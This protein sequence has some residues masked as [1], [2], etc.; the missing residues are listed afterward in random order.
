MKNTLALMGCLL[1]LVAASPAADKNVCL[2]CHSQMDAP[3]K[4][5]QAEFASNIHAEKGLTCTSCHGGDA[6]SDENPMSRAAGFR[7]HIE[8]RQVPELCGSCHGD[9]AKMR[10]YNPSLRTDQ[11][12]QYK[13]SV[14]GKKLAT[15]DQKVA[16]CTDCHTVHDIRPASDPRSSVHP[17]NVAT[18]CKRCHADAVYMKDYKIPHDQFAGYSASVHYKAMHEGGDLSA[19]TCTTCHGN[20]GAAPPGL[21]SVENVCSTCHVFQAQLFDKSP[22]K[23]AFAAAGLAGC[24]T[25]HSNHRITHPSDAMVGTGP[26]SVCTNCHSAGDNGYK[27]A[28][29]IATKFAGLAKAVNESKELLDRASHSGMEVSDAEME[30]VAANDSLTKA[31]VSLHSFNEARVEEDIAAGLK[32]A[33]KTHEDA[34]AALQQREYRRMGLLVSLATILVT[35]GALAF[36]IHQIEQGNSQH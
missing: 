1:L 13:T 33:K 21:A 29:S 24:I 8:R 28:E 25:C 16:V 32:T 14:H 22:H 30:L 26:S 27:T 10:Q 20:H 36:Y 11:L 7:G 18:T 9:A 2:D 3:L 4:V 23:K 34:E 6:T 12:S 35:V 17:L 19:P 5:T 15:G 31:R